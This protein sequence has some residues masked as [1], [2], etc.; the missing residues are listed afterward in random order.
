MSIKMIYA[1]TAA[2]AMVAATPAFGQ[3][4]GPEP[5]GRRVGR[6]RRERNR[7]EDLPHVQEHR[8]AHEGGEGLPDPRGME[9]GRSGADVIA[10]PAHRRPSGGWGPGG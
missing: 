6:R 8:F 4:P 2:L 10:P 9:E 5:A 7:E 3:E 1:S